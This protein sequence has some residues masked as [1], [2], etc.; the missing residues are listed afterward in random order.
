MEEQDLASRIPK[1]HE[2]VSD[3]ADQLRERVSIVARKCTE[4]W[5]RDTIDQFQDFRAHVQKHMELE[6]SQGHMAAVVEQRPSLAP[7][8]DRLLQEHRDLTQLLDDLYI[9]CGDLMP[10]RR[11]LLRD[12]CYRVQN[13]LSYIEHH[14]DEENDLIGLVFNEDIG[15]KD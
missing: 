9:L 13:I 7:R 2:H 5:I 11:L 8:I 12:F 15:T 4:S 14:E 10:D 6:E 3:L 1:E